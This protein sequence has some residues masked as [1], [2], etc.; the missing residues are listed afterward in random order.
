MFL[1]FST[2]DLAFVRCVINRVCVLFR[3]RKRGWDAKFRPDSQ[4]S[5]LIRSSEAQTGT[6]QAFCHFLYGDQKGRQYLETYV[7]NN[8]SCFAGSDIFYLFFPL[9]ISIIRHFV[10]LFNGLKVFKGCFSYYSFSG[11]TFQVVCNIALCE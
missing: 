2:P 3:T 10:N 8:G 5:R 9:K 11:I 7:S 4:T 1:K 6:R